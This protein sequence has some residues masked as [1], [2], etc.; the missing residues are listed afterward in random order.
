MWPTSAGLLV[1]SQMDT[2]LELAVT[3]LI[4]SLNCHTL[5]NQSYRHHSDQTNRAPHN[6]TAMKKGVFLVVR[7]NRVQ[8]AEWGP[9]ASLFTIPLG[10][11]SSLVVE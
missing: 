11:P 5:D 7:E 3:V 8:K 9:E 2:Q 6:R 1:L 4:S 10:T